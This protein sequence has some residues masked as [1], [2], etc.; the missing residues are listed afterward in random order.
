MYGRWAAKMFTPCFKRYNEN[1]L[2]KWSA[3]HCLAFSFTWREIMDFLK[4]QFLEECLPFQALVRGLKE[5]TSLI[6]KSLCG[7]IKFGAINGQKYF[8]LI[9]GTLRFGQI[10]EKNCLPPPLPP[11]APLPNFFRQAHVCEIIKLW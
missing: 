10:R 8:K 9:L 3:N 5:T 7:G 6:K 1:R 11:R 4:A 2:F